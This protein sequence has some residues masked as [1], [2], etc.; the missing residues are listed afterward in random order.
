MTRGIAPDLSGVK[1]GHLTVLKRNGSDRVSNAL[2]LC[3]CAC[4][5]EVSIR[6]MYLKRGR[7]MFCSRTCPLHSEEMCVDITGQKFGRLTAI[8]RVGSS[9][10]GTAIWAFSCDCG[11]EVEFKHYTVRIGHTSSCGCLGKESRIKHGRSQTLEYHREAH[12]KWAK[13][14]PEK[15]IANAMRRTKAKRQRIPKWLTDEHWD[16]IAAFYREAQ[17]K[18]L[19]TGIVHHVDHKYPL[20]GKTCSGLHVPWNLQVTPADVNLRKANKMPIDDVC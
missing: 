6:A 10:G 8:A 19:E 15:V 16:Q 13:A 18:T 12:R 14:N 3:K 5:K 20:R 17:R 4:G 7:Q 11:E 9:A 1:R 2:W